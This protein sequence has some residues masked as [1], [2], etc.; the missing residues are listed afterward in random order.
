MR[1][2][3][4][5]IRKDLI[6]LGN[7]G[8]KTTDTYNEDPVLNAYVELLQTADR[9]IRSRINKGKLSIYNKAFFGDLEFN[10]KEKNDKE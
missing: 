7:G 10:I 4:L 3:I 1:L 6:V 8:L 9:F 2:Y 5:V